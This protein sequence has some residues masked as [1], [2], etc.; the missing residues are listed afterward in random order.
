MKP[1]E[2]SSK[3]PVCG[4]VPLNEH[5]WPLK[6][7][8]LVRGSSPIDTSGQHFSSTS[9]VTGVIFSRMS[10]VNPPS[11]A[12]ATREFPKVVASTYG[13]LD[14]QAVIY[15][16]LPVHDAFLHSQHWKCEKWCL[17]CCRTA[18]IDS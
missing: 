1:E 18:Q 4:V 11:V 13:C 16:I 3:K 6:R 5:E 9:I 12:S 2:A 10:P 17:Q 14:L 15:G 8:C 7:L